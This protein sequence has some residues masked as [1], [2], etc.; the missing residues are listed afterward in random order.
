MGQVG[1]CLARRFS[2]FSTYLES[3]DTPSKARFVYKGSTIRGGLCVQEAVSGKECR[4]NDLVIHN[5]LWFL[6][7]EG[8]K[9]AN[10]R[11]ERFEITNTTITFLIERYETIEL[12]LVPQ[13]EDLRPFLWHNY[14][15]SPQDRFQLSLRYT[16]YLRIDGMADSRKRDEDSVIFRELKTIRQRNLRKAA[17]TQPEFRENGNIELLLDNYAQTIGISAGEF[18]VKRAQMA[19]LMTSDF[20]LKH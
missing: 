5:G 11:D 4:L 9:P 10:R 19:A 13:F 12:A 20:T 18:A 17:N 2:F 16:S 14:H 8:K 3:T 1:Q 6:T 15:E 7:D